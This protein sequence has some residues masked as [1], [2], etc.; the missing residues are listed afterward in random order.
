M[1]HLLMI[2]EAVASCNMDDTLETVTIDDVLLAQ[3]QGEPMD[4]EPRTDIEDP[5]R[6]RGRAYVSAESALRR[7]KEQVKLLESQLKSERS[8]AIKVRIQDD[9][10][11]AE[12]R[13]AAAQADLRAAIDALTE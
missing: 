13:Q 2:K 3:A 4:N 1:I 10:E 8:A 9:L 7:A 6:A 12:Q 5:S 11:R